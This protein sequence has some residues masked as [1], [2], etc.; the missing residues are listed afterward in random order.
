MAMAGG[1]ENVVEWGICEYPE[2]NRFPDMGRTSST[3][4]VGDFSAGGRCGEGT[5]VS[6]AQVS[7]HVESECFMKRLKGR[8][9]QW[10]NRRHGRRGTEK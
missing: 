9:M 10:F 7:G 6:G 2:F 8:F 1:P 4:G 5:G 3:A